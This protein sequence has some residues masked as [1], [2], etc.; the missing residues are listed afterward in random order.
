MTD[1]GVYSKPGAN[2]YRFLVE[3][4]WFEGQNNPKYQATY[5]GSGSGWSAQAIPFANYYGYMGTVPGDALEDKGWAVSFSIPY[6]SLGLSKPAAGTTWRMHLEV[7]NRNSQAGP[8]LGSQTWPETG[9]AAN[10]STWGN[11]RFG[12]PTYTPPALNG[13]QTITVRSGLPGAV[14]KD[15]AV[16]GGAECGGAAYPDYFAEWGLLNYNGQG[17]VNIQNQGNISDWP[18]Y[19][20]YYAT[21]SLPSVPAGKILRSARL[22]LSHMGGSDPTHAVPSWIQVLTVNEDWTESS[23]N[24][25]NTPLARENLGGILIPVYDPNWS[26]PAIWTKL[27]RREWDVSLAV[28]DAYTRGVPLRL[29]LYSADKGADGMHTGKYFVSNDTGDW[30]A[31]NRPTLVI[32]YV[33]P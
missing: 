28:L 19:S 8:A 30:N 2:A 11:L 10:P 29:A 21:F 5:R 26:D 13:A 1:S 12:L 31:A 23:A 33:N 7:F 16:G 20:R 3:V 22:S 17:N 32:E 24:W 6:S 14:V 25:N 15:V 27:P 4:R 18:C 9:S